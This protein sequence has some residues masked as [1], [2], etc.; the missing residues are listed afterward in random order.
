MP[1]L[2]HSPHSRSSR[3]ISQ[4]MLM[5]KLDQIKV[6]IVDVVKGDGSGR[7]DPN[8]A[9]PEGKVPYLVTDN[10]EAIRE[11]VAI[12]MYLDEL[13]GYPFSIK[14]CQAGRGAFLSWMSYYCGVLEPAMVAHFAQLDDPVLKSNFR[15]MTEVSEQ[16]ITGLGDKPYLVGDKLTI[17]DIIMASAFQWAPHLT[18]EAAT[19][20]AWL[21]RVEGAQ[22]NAGL[23]AFETQAFAAL[24]VQA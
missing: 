13:Y 1:T 4:L 14:P 22:D 9:H 20:K 10:G 24:K 12:M 18:P 16:I 2:Y 21:K 6:V 7:R 19:V 17:A 5:G 11:S 3:V 8:N 23:E 15:T